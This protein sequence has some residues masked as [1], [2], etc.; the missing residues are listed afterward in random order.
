[1]NDGIS[2]MKPAQSFLDSPFA[3]GHPNRQLDNAYPIREEESQR[4][5]RAGASCARPRDAGWMTGAWLC[6]HPPLQGSRSLAIIHS[7]HHQQPY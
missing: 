3:M 5:G 4:D 1:M 7:L 2:G 6:R